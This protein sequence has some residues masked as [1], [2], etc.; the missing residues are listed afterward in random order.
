VDILRST[1]PSCSYC[2]GRQTPHSRSWRRR[3][4]TGRNPQTSTAKVTS[5]EEVDPSVREAS[6]TSAQ[7]MRPICEAMIWRP[8]FRE[9]E[10]TVI[11]ERI[12]RPVGQQDAVSFCRLCTVPFDRARGVVESLGLDYPCSTPTTPDDNPLVVVR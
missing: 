12:R 10:L 6:A 4:C 11:F 5:M 3:G 1:T 9:N 2:R 7:P 8:L